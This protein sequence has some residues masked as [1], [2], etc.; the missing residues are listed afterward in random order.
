M[1][2]FITKIDL[3][4]LY[5][6][7]DFL[8]NDVMDALMVFITTLGDGGILWIAI[9]VV[10][11][12][13][14]KTRKCGI[15]MGI[16]LVLGLIFGNG[17][18]KNVVGRIRPFQYVLEHSGEV[19]NLL[20]EKPGEYSF[21]SGHT[22]SSFAAATVIFINNKKWGIPALIMAALIGFSRLY[23][24]VHYPTDILAGAFFGV[25]WAISAVWIVKIISEKIAAKKQASK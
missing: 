2:E 13:F 11:L 12:F 16:A 3:S 23:V 24:F 10:L 21:P 18:I 25:V 22:Q 4:I 19:I 1:F 15:A 5:W 7:Q 20:I 8:A 17:I 6:I 9:A 14:K